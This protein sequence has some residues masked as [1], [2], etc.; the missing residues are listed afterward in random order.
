MEREVS[1]EMLDKVKK[2]KDVWEKLFC[3]IIPWYQEY[4]YFVQECQ[5]HVFKSKL[6]FEEKLYIST[7]AY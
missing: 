1:G 3:T 7:G 6:R 5:I 4:A 2:N